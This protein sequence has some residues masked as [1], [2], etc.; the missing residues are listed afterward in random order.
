M[1]GKASIAAIPAAILL[2]GC[3]G[4]DDGDEGDGE[5][6][7]RA[8]YDAAFQICEPGVRA[9]ADLYAV[10]PTKEAVAAIVTEQVSGGSPPDEVAALEGCLDALNEAEPN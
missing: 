6:N 1:T 4:G 9:T 10:E 3:G 7:R 5:G 8:S 2:A